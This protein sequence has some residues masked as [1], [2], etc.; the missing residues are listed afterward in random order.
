ME[1]STKLLSQQPN[2]DQTTRLSRILNQVRNDINKRRVCMLQE[3]S[4]IIPL[5]VVP[6]YKEK[7]SIYP[8]HAPV[9]TEEF[10]KYIRPQWDLTTLRVSFD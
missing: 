4:T 9:L 6:H 5:C 10:Y 2:T 1:L 3:G 7:I 8:H